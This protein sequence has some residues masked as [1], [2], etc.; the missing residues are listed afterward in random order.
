MLRTPP[1]TLATQAA[2][3]LPTVNAGGSKITAIKAMQYGRRTLVKIETDAGVAGYGPCGGTG[4][5][6]R[7]VIAGLEGG[8]LP[9]LGLIGKD[10]LAIK[11]H[12]HNMFTAYPQRGRQTRV[13]S[14]IDIA[15]WDLA[16]KLLGHPVSKLLGGN[17]RDE[18]Q[19][20]SHC[21]GGD[22]LSKSE[23]RDR[24]QALADDPLGFTAYKVDIHHALGAHMQEYIPSIGPQDARKV[25]RAYTLAREA[26]PEHIDI[27]V[28]CHNE[29]DLPSA[30]RVAQAIEH[31][32]PLFY[33]DPL[34]P[35]YSDSWLALRRSTRLPIMTGENLE[36]LDAAL[37]FLQNQA[38]D[39]LQPDL[40][41]SGG[42]TGTRIIADM[43][44]QYRI[45]ISLHNVSGLALNMASQ[46]LSA[47]IFNCPLME[48][49]RNGNTGPEAASNAPVIR[50][51]KMQVSTAP[52]IGLDLDQDYLQA[53]RADGE[54]WWG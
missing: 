21:P 26:I 22:F 39:I 43:A 12:F 9:H 8:R 29:L 2:S 45:P 54:P 18:I 13:L 15:L 52:G 28:H 38:V 40:I 37:P 36:L 44:A 27:I 53:H 20:Y 42:I 41:N 47:A 35:D 30:I 5:F 10:P 17:F 25:H 4:P 34:A 19:L 31:I 46:Q 1:T 14:G 49:T 33:E 7:S 3:A 11:V 6:A 24:A 48:C 16:G 50:D 51:G 23:W 32:D